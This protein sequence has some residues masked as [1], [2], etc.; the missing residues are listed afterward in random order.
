MLLLSLS[1]Q[2]R[3]Y[4]FTP[5]ASLGIALSGTL[6]WDSGF[7]VNFCLVCQPFL[8]KLSGRHHRSI[9][10]ALCKSI[11]LP[12]SFK[13]S[14]NH[15]RS[16][17]SMLHKVRILRRHWA[18]AGRLFRVPWNFMKKF[19]LRRPRGLLMKKVDF[20]FLRCPRTF[21]QL[22]SAVTTGSILSR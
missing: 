4:S 18:Q 11:P 2:D 20:R 13:A 22:S 6:L 21:F 16:G 9:N 19:G 7:M 14:L 15:G 5:V 3:N 1:I 8:W 12:T 17:W 10:L